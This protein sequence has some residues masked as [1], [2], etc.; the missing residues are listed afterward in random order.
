[1]QGRNNLQFINVNNFYPELGE[2]LCKALPAYHTLTGCNYTASFFKKDT[3]P[4]LEL[5]HKD[6]DAQ[7]VLREL[8][9]LEEIDENIISAIEGYLCK[10]YANKGICKVSAIGEHMLL[11]RYEKIKPEGR[12]NFVKKIL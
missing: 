11:K 3:V 1:M 6:A 9:T 7:I 5:L 4:P 12:L 2:T 10:M 8:S